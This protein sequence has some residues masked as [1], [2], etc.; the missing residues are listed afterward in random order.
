[1][2]FDE[3]VEQIRSIMPDAII[4]R[5]YRTGEIVISTGLTESNGKV[6]KIDDE[7]LK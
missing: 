6:V 5:T 1:M 4:D 7:F 3:L 2:S